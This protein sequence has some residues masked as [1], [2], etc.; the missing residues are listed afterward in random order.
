MEF[1]LEEMSQDMVQSRFNGKRPCFLEDQL[2]FCIYDAALMNGTQQSWSLLMG[3][4]LALQ[5]TEQEECCLDSP[6][7][8]L[9]SKTQLFSEIFPRKIWHQ[10]LVEA[11]IQSKRKKRALLFLQKKISKLLL[12]FL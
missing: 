2:W 4:A 10:A 8:S 11:N 9:L 12:T 7:Y 5:K 3:Q 1:E 6:Q